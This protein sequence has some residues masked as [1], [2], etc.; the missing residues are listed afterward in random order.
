MRFGNS[1]GLLQLGD[2]LLQ[3]QTE[4]LYRTDVQNLL[5]TP[6]V[7]DFEL[8]LRDLVDQLF[9]CGSMIYLGL[10]GQAPV[11]SEFWNALLQESEGRLG[12]PLCL[13]T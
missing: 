13:N 10:L 8:I 1:I 2:E 12:K 4:C 6:A 3:I 9:P 11:K 7:G 5:V